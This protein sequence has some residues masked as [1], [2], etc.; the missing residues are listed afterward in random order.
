MV[1][2]VRT[3]FLPQPRPAPGMFVCAC[4]WKSFGTCVGAS[5]TVF[6]MTCAYRLACSLPVTMTL[7]PVLSHMPDCPLFG[8]DSNQVMQVYMHTHTYMVLK[9]VILEGEGKDEVF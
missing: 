3:S 6:C 1:P 8:R 9:R 2:P 7:H 4:A 5:V